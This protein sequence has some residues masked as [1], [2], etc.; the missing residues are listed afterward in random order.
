MKN[1]IKQYFK[2]TNLI[3]KIL[4]KSQMNHTYLFKN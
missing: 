2:K 4:K 1:L 3:Y